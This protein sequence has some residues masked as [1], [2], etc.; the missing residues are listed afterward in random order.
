M[1]TVKGSLKS[2]LPGML[3]PPWAGRYLGPAG[4][5]AITPLPSGALDFMHQQP[6]WSLDSY[7][8]PEKDFGKNE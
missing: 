3:W 6:A 8:P 1:I 4:T 2:K 7:N 5:V